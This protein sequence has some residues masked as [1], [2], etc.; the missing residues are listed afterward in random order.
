MSSEPACPRTST[1]VS[2][3]SLRLGESRAI[4]RRLNPGSSDPLIARRQGETFVSAG[5]TRLPRVASISSLAFVGR[6][7]A[8]ANTLDRPTPVS[9]SGPSGGRAI[10]ARR[11]PSLRH[12]LSRRVECSSYN[13]FGRRG[14][15]ST[16]AAWR[17]ECPV[18]QRLRPRQRYG[19]AFSD[20]CFRLGFHSRGRGQ[21]RRLWS[22]LGH[23]WSVEPMFWHLRRADRGVSRCTQGRSR[24]SVANDRGPD[25]L[26]R[27]PRPAN[28]AVTQSLSA[29]PVR[30]AR[31]PHRGC[32]HRACQGCGLRARTPSCR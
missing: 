19:T 28:R 12:R 21:S 14:G 20:A 27:L 9:L 22:C 31:R 13:G 24:L 16:A 5:V 15:G 29:R 23:R 2:N 10:A 1:P 18:R 4:R 3:L 17:V 25:P 7:L 32:L 8:N 26:A 30:R 6:Q 11:R